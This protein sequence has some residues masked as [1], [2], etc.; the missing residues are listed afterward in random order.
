MSMEVVE[1]TFRN[2]VEDQLVSDRLTVIWHAGEPLVAPPAFYRESFQA[3]QR[4]FGSCTHV[5]HAIQTNGML[6][7]D[8]WCRLFRD[9]NV[10]VGVSLDGPA[11]IHDLHRKTRSGGPTHARV[12]RG[13]ECLR[14]A[15][16]P[17]H[18]IA[19][20]TE[21]SIGLAAELMAFFTEQGITQIG[22][23]IDEAEGAHTSSMVGKESA[24]GAFMS[25]VL[26]AARHAPR[27]IHVREIRNAMRAIVDCGPEIEL[28]GRKVPYNAQVLPAAILTVN[29]QGGFTSWS[30]ELI[31]FRHARF[32][33]FVLGNLRTQSIRD[34]LNSPKATAIQREIVAG[35]AAC[36]RTCEYFSF[37]GGGAPMNKIAECGS[38]A[39]TE[40][41]YCRCTIQ[42]PLNVSLNALEETL[43][44]RRR[45]G[46]TSGVG[47]SGTPRDG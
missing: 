11:H 44:S 8:E 6:I 22:F 15:R 13:I 17:F 39:G 5:S 21:D 47:S 24:Y 3:A 4:I 43:H 28:D 38:F 34:C 29:W 1:A 9:W 31:D 16:L 35:V 7:N 41:V 46:R 32:G 20:V 36:A 45:R 23:N 10:N 27:E 30:P 19:V 37:C 18:V 25:G 14:N 33:D 40:T 42:A 26:D 12:M 2:L